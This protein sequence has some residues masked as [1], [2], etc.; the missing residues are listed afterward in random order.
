M[1]KKTAILIAAVLLASQ[2]YGATKS[3]EKTAD[4]ANALELRNCKLDR[5]AGFPASE[6]CKLL[7]DDH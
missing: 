1:Y 5:D 3:A 7:L 4:A 2:F 6:K